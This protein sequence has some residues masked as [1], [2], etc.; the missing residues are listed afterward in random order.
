MPARRQHPMQH[1]Q[2][3]VHAHCTG[4]SKPAHIEQHQPA[5]TRMPHMQGRRVGVELLEPKWSWWCCAPPQRVRLRCCAV[6]VCVFFFVA[7]VLSLSLALARSRALSSLSLTSLGGAPSER[8]LA[9]AVMDTLWAA[10]RQIEVARRV[11][12]LAGCLVRASGARPWR[13]RRAQVRRKVAGMARRRRF[14][15]ASGEMVGQ[16]S[17]RRC[18]LV[19]SGRCRP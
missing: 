8:F 2:T 3:H 5:S 17:A 19:P 14:R 15:R 7:G 9:E 1:M 16:R 12:K 11:P 10:R 13:P 18:G 6:G 4:A